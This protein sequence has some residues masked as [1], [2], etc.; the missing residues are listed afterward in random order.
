MVTQSPDFF[1]DILDQYY[2][3]PYVVRDFALSCTFERPFTGTWQGLHSLQRYPDTKKVFFELA[4]RMPA[5]GTPNWEQ[6]ETSRDFWGRPSAGMFALLLA[7][8]FDTV[9]FH[10]RSG[11]WAGVCY[12]SLP[13]DCSD[14]DGV[15]F[16]RH[17]RTGLTNCISATPDQIAE[18]RNDGSHFDA[19]EVVQ[20]IPMRFNRM[21]LFD[22][23]C[24]HA[25]SN[26]FGD[27]VNNGRLTQ[28]FNIDF[29]NDKVLQ[30]E[31][32]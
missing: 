13:K 30:N 14:R 22:G 18:L 31:S 24:F 10:R 8:Q 9:H 6:I 19:W 20:H 3:D 12:L 26:G 32:S 15:I 25:A 17:L 2:P 21:V 28:L 16:F 1:L 29:V 23:R 11:A 7:N 5:V 27:N 4:S